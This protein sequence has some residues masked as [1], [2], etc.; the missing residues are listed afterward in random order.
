MKNKS[1]IYVLLFFSNL[2]MATV[3]LPNFFSKGMVLQ[4]NSEVKIWGWANP[5]EEIKISISAG[6]GLEV[7]LT[8]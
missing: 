3:S 8:E 1:I 5:K 4:R 2:M 6:Y 7:R